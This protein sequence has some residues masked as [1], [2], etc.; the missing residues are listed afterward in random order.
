MTFYCFTNE[1]LREYILGIL[2]ST[3]GITVETVRTALQ[4]LKIWM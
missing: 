3:G 1:C 2:E 4:S